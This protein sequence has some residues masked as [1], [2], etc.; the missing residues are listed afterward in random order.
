[1]DYF[2]MQ[3]SEEINIKR[4]IYVILVYKIID[5]INLLVLKEDWWM[6]GIGQGGKRDSKGLL[7]DM[8]EFR[9]GCVQYFNNDNDFM[10]ILNFIKDYIFNM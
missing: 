3:L 8:R 1:M 6:F 5:D 10:G 7:K 2:K 4:S 9:G